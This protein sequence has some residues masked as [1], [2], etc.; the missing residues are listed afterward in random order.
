MIC[1][2]GRVVYGLPRGTSE[3]LGSVGVRVHGR[4]GLAASRIVSSRR[5]R[6]HAAVRVPGRRGPRV[7]TR[8]L[9][10]IAARLLLL[11]EVLGLG[12]GNLVARGRWPL[13][14]RIVAAL[15]AAVVDWPVS[16][17]IWRLAVGPG[18]L[19]MPRGR[20]TLHG[21]SHGVGATLL[22]L[23]LLLMLHH[24]LGRGHRRRGHG[25]RAAGAG[26]S[27]ED[28]IEGGLPLEVCRVA[29]VL[30]RRALVG[31]AWLLALLLLLLLLLIICHVA[32]DHCD[33]DKIIT[34]CSNAAR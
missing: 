33:G 4:A 10:G 18:A 7:E 9:A 31:A 23:P 19:G 1:T 34:S 30:R 27:A 14:A 22:L 12:R 13:G 11:L 6:P 29:I 20:G 2:R 25:L 17:R 8:R 15:H 16:G 3:G 21:A 26:S 28:V 24:E 32:V 5:W